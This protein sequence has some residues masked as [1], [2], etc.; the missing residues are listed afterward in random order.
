VF[1]V[2]LLRRTGPRGEGGTVYLDGPQKLKT[3]AGEILRCAQDD[4]Q[5]PVVGL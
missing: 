2:T 3:K 5:R 1:A 4:G